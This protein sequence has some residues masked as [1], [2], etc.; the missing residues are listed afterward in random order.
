MVVLIMGTTI[1]FTIFAPL[2]NYKRKEL[3]SEVIHAAS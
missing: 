1:F 2:I 3:C